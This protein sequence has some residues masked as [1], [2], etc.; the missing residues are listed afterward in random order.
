MKPGE[1]AGHWRAGRCQFESP[2]QCAQSL[3]V[4]PL[5]SQDVA[6]LVVAEVA[7]GLSRIASR[8]AAMASS[9]FP[10]RLRALPR[11]SWARASR[12]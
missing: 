12:A 6:E 2:T 5:V 9:S 4:L 7:S 11:L 10:W 1:V 3:L 8:Y